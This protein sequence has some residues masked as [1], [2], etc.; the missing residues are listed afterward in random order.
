M[1]VLSDKIY[2]FF[3]GWK[4]PVFT[5]AFLIFFDIFI[6]SI[7]FI[8]P[9]DDNLLGQFAQTFRI[10]CF[11]ED[12]E[13]KKSQN[14]YFL[15][16][17]LDPLLLIGVIVFF[18]Q[19][20]LKEVLSQKPKEFYKYI[21]YA[22][23][24]VFLAFIAF[25]YLT[26]EDQKKKESL[27][28]N[29]LR[30][31]IPLKSANLISHR[32]ESINPKD[33]NGKVV[34]ITSF[35]AHCSSMCPLILRDVREVV[36]QISDKTNLAILAITMDPE[37]DNPSSLLEI[38]KSYKMEESFYYFLTGEKQ[39]INQYLDLLGFVRKYNSKTKEYSHANLVLHVDK[40]NN[41]S[42]QFTIGN[43]QK[44]LIIDAL[45]ILLKE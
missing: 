9:V 3:A 39:R 19:Q 13:M 14:I 18:W 31:H 2:D 35:Y 44:K 20:P 30:V 4:F 38:A 37:R 27:I 40:K 33:F 24:P 34:L 17:I 29:D 5:I 43:E 41:I 11:G 10:W 32:G 23:I 45:K 26:F 28:I 8:P 1:A 15:M 42:F 6:I 7:W 12:P 21:L 25:L 16:F 22:I 36:N